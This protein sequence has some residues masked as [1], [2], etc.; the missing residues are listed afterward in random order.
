M[1]RSGGVGALFF[2][3]QDRAVLAKGRAA[4]TCTRKQIWQRPGNG[5]GNPKTTDTTNN[6][7][8]A[9]ITVYDGH[10]QQL[11]HAG[12]PMEA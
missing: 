2:L 9:N 8:P 1:S 11:T 3:Q 10:I 12:L 6:R 5:T 7:V 4:F